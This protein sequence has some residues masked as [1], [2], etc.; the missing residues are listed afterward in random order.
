MKCFVISPI[1]Q[2]GSEV[3][4]HAD[5]VFEHL[6]EPALAE[7]GIQPVRSDQMNEPGKISDQMYRSIFGHD[8]CIAVLTFA[9][10]NVYYELAIAQSAA[11]PVIVLIEKGSQL[12]FDVADLRTLSYDLRITS[13]KNR[14]YI[15]KLS[16]MLEELKQAGWRGQDSFRQYR[17]HLGP[18]AQALV[19][20]AG[21][22]IDTPD[23]SEP[24][25]RIDISGKIEAIPEGYELR[26]LRYYP[27]NHTFVPLGK[28]V[29]DRMSKTWRV[30]RFDIGGEG[31]AER[32]IF[33]A[34]AGQGA[35]LLLDYF[36]LAADAHYEVHK[37]LREATGKS[38][39][40]L[41]SIATWP[42]DLH[43]CARRM[44]RRK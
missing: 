35:K 19:A 20:T 34:L 30:S 27:D 3:R 25:E 10:P 22:T 29:V 5:E 24:I 12:P 7:F 14:T 17:V 41:P 2:E 44:V 26:T 13:Y 6:I 18:D 11:R 23:G 16:S 15:A 9:N 31:G 42:E 1:G 38:G 21:A 43:V 28:V 39:R 36:Q 40:Y 33:L 37:E 8:L 4:A 32:G